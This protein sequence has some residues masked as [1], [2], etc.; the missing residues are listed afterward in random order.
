MPQIRHSMATA[1]L[2]G[3]MLAAARLGGPDGHWFSMRTART[4]PS[5]RAALAAE[6]VNLLGPRWEPDDPWCVFNVSAALRAMVRYDEV[7]DADSDLIGRVVVDHWEELARYL[8]MATG[9]AGG[10]LP[11]VR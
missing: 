1:R 2:N 9:A 4:F 3:T 5:A 10:P 8:E 6:A 11:D 7:F